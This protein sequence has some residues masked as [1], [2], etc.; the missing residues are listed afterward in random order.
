MGTGISQPPGLGG[1]PQ[2]SLQH[3]QG[4][5]LGVAN[6]RLDTYR[7]T[8]RRTLRRSLQQIIRP[9]V[10]CGGEGV[11]VGVHEGLQVRRWISNVDLGHPP[12]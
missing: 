3:R 6:P 11:Q 1:E 12:L 8:P 7:R 4:D 10:E 9:G 5:K 2:Q